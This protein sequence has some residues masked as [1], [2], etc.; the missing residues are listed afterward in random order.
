MEA[1]IHTEKYLRDENVKLNRKLV[2]EVDRREA[3]TK[4]LSESETSFEIED[5]KHFHER[6]R[7]S[8]TS[9][10]SLSPRRSLSPACKFL[11]PI[12]F[13]MSAV[14]SRTSSISSSISMLITS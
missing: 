10:P 8:C 4:Q 3:L 14:H 9:S 11:L 7:H 1:F 5:E 13:I 12:V 2:R 6:H